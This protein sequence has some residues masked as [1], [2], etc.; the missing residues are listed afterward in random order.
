[1]EVL[2]ALWDGA[3]GLLLAVLEFFYGMTNSYGL[4]IVLLTIL[5]RLALYP[6]KK[7]FNFF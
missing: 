2:G 1:M 4:A 3:S 5:V 6:L 7:G